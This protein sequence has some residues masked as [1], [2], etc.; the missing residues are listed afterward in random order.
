MR[1][2]LF[3]FR[4]RIQGSG[5]SAIERTPIVFLL[6]TGVSCSRA[7]LVPRPPVISC[8]AHKARPLV[9][10]HAVSAFLLAWRCFPSSVERRQ[11][12]DVSPLSV[13]RVFPL[14]SSVRTRG[15]GSPLTLFQIFP[16]P[17]T[18]S[19]AFFPHPFWFG[20]DKYFV[21]S[22][23]PVISTFTYVISKS[24]F[25]QLRFLRESGLKKGEASC[26]MLLQTSQYT[27][28]K[29]ASSIK[30]AS[31]SSLPPNNFTPEESHILKREDQ[32]L[33]IE[34]PLFARNSSFSIFFLC[35]IFPFSFFSL[36][37]KR[38]DYH[39]IVTSAQRYEVKRILLSEGAQLLKGL[40]IKKAFFKKASLSS[41][42]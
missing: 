25:K 23:T 24:A 19:R 1:I 10:P 29:V 18:L 4:K 38:S 2:K 31:S 22:R 13:R 11:K 30:L 39:R 28:K 41:R 20:D 8:R 16:L 12:K 35:S 9:L 17:R 33:I 21:S 7:P 42:A 36:K 6:F 3:P 40:L 37:G 32:T 27:L 15:M 26:V 34:F 5:P 14:M